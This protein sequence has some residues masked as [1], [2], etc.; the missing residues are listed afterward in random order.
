MATLRIDFFHDV[1]CAWCY[2]LSPR[3]ERLVRELQDRGMKVDLHHHTF[4]LA[5]EPDDLVR[6]FGS[7]EEAKREI[8]G[9]WQQ[10]AAHD[11]EAGR[12]R[13]DLMAQRPF[14]YPH[15]TPGLLACA[16]AQVLD[17]SEGHGRYF[18]HVQ[19][20]HL[21]ECR[22]IANRDTLLDIAQECGFERGLFA[23]TM[24]GPQARDIPAA[25]RQLAALW[26]VHAVPTL[27]LQNRWR[28]SGALPYER[29]RAA[30]EQVLASD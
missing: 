26:G 25:D 20:A 24:D 13:P 17:G 6:M 14:P 18:Q 9:H 3:L 12:I 19:R 4:A 7:R 10:A 28:I 30:V 15:S 29:L 5:P 1:L 22:D 21:T 2:V 16:A 23:E 8:L 27:I 11:D